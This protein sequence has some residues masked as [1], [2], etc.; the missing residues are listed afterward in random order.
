MKFLKVFF[1]VLWLLIETMF[2]LAAVIL[3]TIPTLFIILLGFLNLKPTN[4]ATT[5]QAKRDLYPRADQ[6]N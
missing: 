3:I 4:N 2:I 5:N 1:A 6:L